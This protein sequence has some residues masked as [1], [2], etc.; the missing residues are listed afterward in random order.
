MFVSVKSLTNYMDTLIGYVL[1][2][3]K[4]HTCSEEKY[5]KYIESMKKKLDAQLEDLKSLSSND[6]L[7]SKYE[8]RIME[9]FK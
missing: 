1:D 3:K 8:N 2:A 5:M 7:I 9:V 4:N 6:K